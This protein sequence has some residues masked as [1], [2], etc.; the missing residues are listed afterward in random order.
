MRF[1]IEGARLWRATGYADGGVAVDGGKV[2]VD[3]GPDAPRLDVGGATLLPGIVNGHDHLDFSS[4]QLQGTPPYASLYA[5]AADVRGGVGD[6]GA[7]AA[8][9]VPLVDRL[10]LG[11]LR[12]LL[13]GVTAVA[14]H[15]PDHR[16]LGRADFPVRVLRRYQF[17][18]SPGLTSRLRSTYRSTD[19]RI[20]WMIHAAEGTDAACRAEVGQLAEERLLRQNTVLVHAIAVGP[21]DAARIAA[22]RAGVVWCPES[23]RRLYAATAPVGLLLQ[24]GVALGLGSDSPV[25]GVRDALSNLAAA[26]A[27]GVLSDGQLLELAT[28]GTAAVARLPVGGFDPGDPA[29]LIVV[30]SVEELLRGERGAIRLVVCGGRPLL[31]EPGLMRALEVPASPLRIDGQARLLAEP[32]CRRLRA[33]LREQ[34]FLREVA[35]IHGVGFD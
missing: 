3:A 8:L 15:G 13:A 2:V 16:C 11:G 23:N 5:W 35:W 9:G 28:R 24:A 29:D 1:G 22:A 14:H 20:P 7:R 32:S 31:G 30:S 25:S 12:C 4:F 27:E 33:A 18:H 26:R 21:E 10:W 34:P 6:A 17:A 19:R